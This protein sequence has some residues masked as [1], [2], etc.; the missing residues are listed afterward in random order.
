ML[1]CL[2]LPVWAISGGQIDDFENGSVQGWSE[3]GNSSNPPTNQPSGGPAGADD[4]Y[5]RNESSGEGA[6]GSRMTM[7]NTQQW[8]GDYLAAGI[9]AIEADMINLGQEPLSMRVA[10]GSSQSGISGGSWYASS[11]PNLLPVGGG[12]QRV[13]FLLVP[14][15]LTRVQGLGSLDLVLSQVQELR[16][17]SSQNPA[18]GG[19]Q[20]AGVL[21]VDNIRA[22]TIGESL[23]IT[24]SVHPL[25]GQAGSPVTYTLRFANQGAVD[26]RNVVIEDTIPALIQVTQ[27]VSSGVPLS[28]SGSGPAYVWSAGTIPPTLGGV[29]TV[30]GVI[31]PELPNAP[32]RIVNSALIRGT[33]AQELPLGNQ[34]SATIWVRLLSFL[35]AIFR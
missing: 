24:K 7:F 11:Q 23:G 31:S 25:Y 29:I 27:I 14:F 3:G 4:N 15:A 1:L 20:I 22:V 10:L 18:K 34:S 16:M 30:T 12:W 9:V 28:S 26:A 33:D 32:T 6:G 35:P 2:A 13:R 19:D 21:G 5:L 17:V 8:Q